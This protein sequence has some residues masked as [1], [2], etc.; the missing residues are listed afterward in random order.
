MKGKQKQGMSLDIPE[1][2]RDTPNYKPST[3]RKTNFLQ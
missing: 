1:A 2:A 3:P